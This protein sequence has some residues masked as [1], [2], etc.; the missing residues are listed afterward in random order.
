[1]FVHIAL[2]TQISKALIWH[3]H[4]QKALDKVGILQRGLAE[5]QPLKEVVMRAYGKRIGSW[6]FAGIDSPNPR[7]AIIGPNRTQHLLLDL[8]RERGGDV[9]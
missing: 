7:A 6:L 5:A 3:V 9:G 4:A 2:P 8:L 1:M